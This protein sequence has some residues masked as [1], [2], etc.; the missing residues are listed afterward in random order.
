MRLQRWNLKDFLEKSI[1]PSATPD[2][3]PNLETNYID[4]A[5]IRLK[6]HEICL[7]Q[8][9]VAFNDNNIPNY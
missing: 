7:K 4:N 6:F 1:K 8:E 9:K 5:I 3:S 2:N